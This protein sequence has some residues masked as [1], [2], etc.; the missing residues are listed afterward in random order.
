VTELKTMTIELPDK[1]AAELEALVEAG[2]FHS[3]DEAVRL[4]LVEFLR[5]RSL[6]LAERFQEEDIRW[7]LEQRPLP[8]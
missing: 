6:D 7:A 1:V 8:R 5:H 3:K 2:W 4:A